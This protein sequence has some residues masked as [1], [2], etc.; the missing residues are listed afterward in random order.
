M[1]ELYIYTS[2]VTFYCPSTRPGQKDWHFTCLSSASDQLTCFPE[3][4]RRAMWILP[5][6]SQPQCPACQE[7]KL[8]GVRRSSR[9]QRH[10]WRGWAMENS[11]YNVLSLWSR[12]VD[13]T[14]GG[15]IC[16]KLFLTNSS[17]TWLLRLAFS[18]ANPMPCGFYFFWV[19]V[20][21]P[22]LAGLSDQKA[23]RQWHY[24]PQILVLWLCEGSIRE[25]YEELF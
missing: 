5:T 9:E 2:K 19:S 13:D 11:I 1:G 7:R 25:R 12:E 17:K 20:S 3:I 21:L 14:S 6:L 24:W 15:G 16:R 10:S 4:N 23:F 8:T 18:L 22:V